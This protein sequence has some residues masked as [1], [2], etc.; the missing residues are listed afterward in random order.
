MSTEDLQQALE[1]LQ[2][3]DHHVHG[4]LR[5]D[6]DRLALEGML[7]ESDRPIP[8]WMTQFDSQVGFAVRRWC[9]PLLDLPAGAPADEYMARRTALGHVEVSRRLLAASGVDHYLVE[10]GHG[11]DEVMGPAEMATVSGRNAHEVVRLEKVLE[12][13]VHRGMGAEEAVRGFAQ[14]LATA[15]AHAVGVKSIVAY[16]FG[17]DF[18]PDRPDHLEVVTAMG[19]WLKRGEA[20]GTFRVADPVLLRFLL[21]SAVDRGLPIQL[22]AGYGDPD[23]DL[24]RTDPLLL[25]AFI[26]LVEPHAVDLLLLHCYPYHR[27]AGY[28]AQAF[29]HVFFDV[30]L[31]LNYTGMQSHAVVAESLELAPFAKV[32]FSSDAWGPPELHYLGARLWRRGM[33][34]AL[35]SWVEAG[36]WST[37]D[38]ARVAQMIGRDNAAR[39]YRLTRDS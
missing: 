11:S 35:S 7:S 1:D 22:H 21:W 15:T 25:T 18:Q 23:L 33:G 5:R 30:G 24:H 27:H 20:D 29:P 4:A 12:S 19:A 39:V 31:G 37:G 38:A 17:F 14:A 34:R 9:A 13:L 6:V 10:T 3:I 8:A 28:L 2:L 32:L 36:E 16:R 26:R